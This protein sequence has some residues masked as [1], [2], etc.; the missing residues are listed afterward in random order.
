VTLVAMVVGVA[1]G[2]FSLRRILFLAAAAAPPRAVRETAPGE[3]PA[4]AVIVPACNEARGIDPTLSALAAIDYP[5][6]RLF[7]VLV[8]DRSDDDT[9]VHRLAGGRPPRAGPARTA[10]K[11]ARRRGGP[12]AH[13]RRSSSRPVTR[14]SARAPDYFRRSRRRVR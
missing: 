1:L 13:W 3:L 9:A 5:S 2:C 8:D 6:E 14:T 11:A 10:R 7:V 4:L 12:G